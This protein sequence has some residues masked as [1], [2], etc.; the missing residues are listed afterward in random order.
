MLALSVVIAYLCSVEFLIYTIMAN[1]K[2]LHEYKGS[3]VYVNLD[4][5]IDV[6]PDKNGSYIRYNV[7]YTDRNALRSLTVTESPEEVVA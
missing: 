1:F 5:V 4:N 3:E 7:P 2:L 6:C